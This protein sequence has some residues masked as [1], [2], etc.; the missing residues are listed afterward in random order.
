MFAYMGH[1]KSQRKL[2]IT[3]IHAP[4]H[5]EWRCLLYLVAVDPFFYCIKVAGKMQVNI[6]CRQDTGIS[7]ARLLV[8]PCRQAC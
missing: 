8:A 2:L 3:V 5:I 4:A 7:S 1:L 6:L